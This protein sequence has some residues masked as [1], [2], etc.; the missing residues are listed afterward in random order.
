M[1]GTLEILE[2]AS[3]C[4]H[5]PRLLG[6]LYA[7]DFDEVAP[8]ASEPSVQPELPR[9]LTAEDL[10]RACL[11]AVQ[12]ARAEWEQGEQRRRSELLA[13]IGAALAGAREE[14]TR[15]ALAAA[16]GTASTLLAML[17][18]ALPRLCRDYGA[19]E[20]RNLVQRL[21]P[22]LRAEPRITIRVHSDLVS[23]VQRD[24]AQLEPDLAGTVSILPAPMA[25]GDVKITWENGSFARDSQQIL[26]AMQDVL[27]LLGVH[28]TIEVLE[29]RRMALAE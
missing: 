27:S 22:V 23:A 25:P 17:S 28:E 14:A 1:D 19:A 3:A 10:D 21:L 24:V 18:G 9:A 11:T 2:Q 13:S 29:E 7:E 20:V 12:S 5:S 4:G 15:L 26:A 16:E 6:I 8:A